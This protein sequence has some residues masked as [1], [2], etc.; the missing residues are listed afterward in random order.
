MH[1]L[2]LLNESVT[3][4]SN[5]M[6]LNFT[7][8]SFIL[9]GILMIISKSPMVSVLFLICLR[10][11]SLLL[12]KLRVCVVPCCVVLGF[13]LL[14]IF[15]FFYFGE[16]VY[17]MDDIA[18]KIF[19]PQ[20]TRAYYISQ[21]HEIRLELVESGL[22]VADSQLSK[23]HLARKQYLI[24]ALAD[25]QQNVDSLGRIIDSLNK[26]MQNTEVTVTKRFFSDLDQSGP[27][28]KRG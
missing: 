13:I 7:S 10:K 14:A 12:Q 5:Y 6:I 3:S 8:L 9:C 4:G 18:E 11:I 20:D 19:K 26:P 25:S 15:L 2:F 17:C 23:E 27:S 1:K 21:I 24:Q 22:N 28:K 16:P